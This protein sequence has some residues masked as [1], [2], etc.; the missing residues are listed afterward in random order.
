MVAY[1]NSRVSEHSYSYMASYACGLNYF[2]LPYCTVCTCMHGIY[3][4][5]R[6]MHVIT[7]V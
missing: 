3:I 5:P 2:P 6:D 7:L 4:V 1:W